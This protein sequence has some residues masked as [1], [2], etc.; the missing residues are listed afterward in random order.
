MLASKDMRTEGYTVGQTVTHRSF[1]DDM[2]SML[3]LLLFIL[4]V[5]CV[6]FILGVE[7]VE[8]QGGRGEQAWDG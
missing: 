1:R 5:C 4:F 3:C 7:M 8:Y 2:F 6:F